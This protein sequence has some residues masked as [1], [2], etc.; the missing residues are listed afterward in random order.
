DGLVW[1]CQGGVFVKLGLSRHRDH[2]IGMGPGGA[3]LL[4]R[5][6]W[7]R[8]HSPEEPEAW[9]TSVPAG[10][11]T[12]FGQGFAFRVCAGGYVADPATPV[13]DFPIAAVDLRTGADHTLILHVPYKGQFPE[14]ESNYSR[15]KLP[16]G[17]DAW[18]TLG[19]H[20]LAVTGLQVEDNRLRV[21]L[22]ME[23]WA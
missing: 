18:H 12:A 4:C 3:D 16:G 10:D 6:E 8:Q 14:P 9:L 1:A 22:G 17:K 11:P 23:D 21:T 2:F 7:Y 20:V 19:P 13:Y 5:V 15:N